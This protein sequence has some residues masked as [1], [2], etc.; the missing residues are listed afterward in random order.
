MDI[1]AEPNP[2]GGAEW[3][4]DCIRPVEIV[5]CRDFE[6]ARVAFDNGDF[7]AAGARDRGV[8]GIGGLGLAGAR[9]ADTRRRR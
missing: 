2:D 1:E 5:L 9:P 8:V 6:I 7:Q 3:P 4:H